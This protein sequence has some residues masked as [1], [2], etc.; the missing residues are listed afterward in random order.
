[1]E[2]F[3]HKKKLIGIRIRGFKPG[4]TSITEEREALQA[5]AM[6]RPAGTIVKPHRHRP[7]KRVTST[8][9]ECLVLISGSIRVDLFGSEKKV[10]K[11]VTLKPGDLFIT[12]SGGH[13]VTFLTDSKV[14]EIKNG[15]YRDDRNNFE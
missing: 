4:V 15:P 1:M 9:Q 3:F 6:Q 11:R 5:L 10:V 7:T 13:R 2:K 8:L 14:F 12:I